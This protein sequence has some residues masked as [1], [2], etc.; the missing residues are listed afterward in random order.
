MSLLLRLEITFCPRSAF[1]TTASQGSDGKTQ[2]EQLFSSL[3]TRSRW[4]GHQWKNQLCSERNAFCFH[5]V[6]CAHSQAVSGQL[7]TLNVWAA[8]SIYISCKQQPR[9]LGGNGDVGQKIIMIGPE[10]EHKSNKKRSVSP[11]A[12]MI[13]KRAVKHTVNKYQFWRSSLKQLCG[14]CLPL[15]S[16][17]LRWWVCHRAVSPDKEGDSEPRTQQKLRGSN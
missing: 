1:R 7:N 9:L 12:P 4:F 5:W 8:N 13:K 17:S 2:K 3:I 16:F 14:L 15:A 10:N 6:R 11:P